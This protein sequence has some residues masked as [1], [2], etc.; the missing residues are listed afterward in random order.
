MGGDADDV[1]W[2]PTA[3]D[4]LCF[5]CSG[6]AFILI[7][8]SWR[9]PDHCRIRSLTSRGFF[10]FN[11]KLQILPEDRKKKLFPLGFHQDTGEEA[12]VWT[13]WPQL[14]VRARWCC[15]GLRVRWSCSRAGVHVYG[16]L[17]V[18]MSSSVSCKNRIFIH[19]LHS[20]SFP[21]RLCVSVEPLRFDVWPHHQS[22][23]SSSGS[24]LSRVGHKRTNTPHVNSFDFFFFLLR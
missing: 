11:L 22:I 17:L 8:V 21:H 13:R 15:S 9:K 3:A 5:T 10:L 7:W 2:K 23:Q 14:H 18:W 12:P 19:D 16:S 20:V 24:D 1:S 4:I 6:G